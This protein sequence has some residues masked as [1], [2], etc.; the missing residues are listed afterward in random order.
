MTGLICGLKSHSKAT[1][2][3][4][5]ILQHSLV[6]FSSFCI[7][8]CLYN[9][10]LFMPMSQPLPTTADAETLGLE[11]PSPS[12]ADVT[13]ALQPKIT[14]DLVDSPTTVLHCCRN[15]Q[16]GVSDQ[17]VTVCRCSYC[18]SAS[19]WAAGRRRRPPARPWRCRGAPAAPPSPCGRWCGSCRPGPSPGNQSE[20]SR[21]RWG[22][23][24]YGS[25]PW[26]LPQGEIFAIWL[27]KCV[28]FS[29]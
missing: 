27:F 13:D 8:F 20:T 15:V 28:C 4:H 25:H 24:F 7:I 3:Q 9:L 11:G 21:R 1:I 23:P 29:H 2:K 18:P 5:R 6:K 17:W 14:S 26:N 10:G 16:Q 22:Q 19:S 12:G